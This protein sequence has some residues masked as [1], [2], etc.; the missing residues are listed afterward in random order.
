MSSSLTLVTCTRNPTPEIFLRVLDGVAALRRPADHAIEYAIIDST[1]EPPL[2]SRPEVIEFLGRHPW[3]RLIRAAAPGH[4]AARRAAVEATSGELLIW[5][6]DDNVPA[7][8]YLEQVIATSVAWPEV[9]V[10]GAG[11]IKVEFV[12]PVPQWVER[13]VRPT[14]QQRS[15][16]RDE[17]GRATHWAP[18]FPVGSGLVTRREAIERWATAMRDGRYSLA[19]RTG[20]QLSSGD[21]AQIIF[22]AVAAGESVGVAAAQ[23]LAHLISG[24]RCTMEYLTRLEFGLSGS[25]R[26]AR[27]ECFPDDPEPRSLSGL[28]ALRALRATIARLRRHGWR[29]ARFEAARRLGAL[30]GTLQTKHRREPFW[31]RAAVAAMRLR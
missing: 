19:G 18:F 9:T 27:A 7:P 20:S 13:E 6:D 17:F 21:D 3:A 12:D 2:S 4:S 16:A 31:L 1:S 5:F 25:I 23:R 14:F 11:S 10:W 22:G 26:V 15:H 8:D 28:G 24:R 30:S 29:A